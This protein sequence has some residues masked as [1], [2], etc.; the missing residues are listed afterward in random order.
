M[1]CSRLLKMGGMGGIG[2]DGLIA[3]RWVDDWLV[4]F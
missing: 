2:L 3:M 1:W 4:L